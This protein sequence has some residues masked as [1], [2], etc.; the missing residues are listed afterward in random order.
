MLVVKKECSIVNF[1]IE[2]GLGA[3]DTKKM[4]T[5]EEIVRATVQVAKTLTFTT[6]LKKPAFLK[7]AKDNKSVI[8]IDNITPNDVPH[9][10]PS[11]PK[12]YK[13]N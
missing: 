6:K 8:Y 7:D 10:I 4:V 1:K 13:I 11:A 9:T 2:P 3:K 5:M 12:K